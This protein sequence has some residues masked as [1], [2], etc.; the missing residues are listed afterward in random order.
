MI[1]S[2][3]WDQ[4]LADLAASMPEPGTDAVSRLRH[5]LGAF[6]NMSD[7]DMALCATVGI[8]PEPTGITWGDLREAFKALE[9]LNTPLK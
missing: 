5:T 3:E 4:H 9:T 8:W 6:S 1:M 2:T 7:D